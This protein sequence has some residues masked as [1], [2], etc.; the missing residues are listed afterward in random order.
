[1]VECIGNSLIISFQLF[2]PNDGSGAIAGVIGALRLD[3]LAGRLE[4]EYGFERD[5][6]DN[7]VRNSLAGSRRKI[8]PNATVLF[9]RTGAHGTR[10]RRRADLHGRL[11]LRPEIDQDTWPEVVIPD[12]YY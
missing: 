5:F 12:N 11:G 8:R 4:A 9:T 2:L 1:M 7:P 6:R 3:V 10:S